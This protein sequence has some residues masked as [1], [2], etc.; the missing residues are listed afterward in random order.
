MTMFRLLGW[1]KPSEILTECNLITMVH[2]PEKLIR[3]HYYYMYANQNWSY[4]N[5]PFCRWN[6]IA[7]VDNCASFTND[8]FG[9]SDSLFPSVWGYSC[10]KSNVAHYFFTPRKLSVFK[11]MSPKAKFYR[12]P[13]PPST[14]RP[15]LPCYNWFCFNIL[16]Y[17]FPV[18]KAT[19]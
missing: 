6:G 7:N 15:A 1:D 10:Y 19:F 14:L 3:G 5:G 2:L 8:N 4:S 11:I 16:F 12:A 13:A 18:I 9:N 17:R